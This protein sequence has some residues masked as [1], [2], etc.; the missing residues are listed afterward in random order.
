VIELS[1]DGSGVGK[2][3]DIGKSGDTR[4]QHGG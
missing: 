3:S 2:C 1:G 4:V